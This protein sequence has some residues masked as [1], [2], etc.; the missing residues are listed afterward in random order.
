V[1]GADLRTVDGDLLTVFG[2]FTLA[3]LYLGEA[4][5]AEAEL[6]TL[7]D[8]DKPGARAA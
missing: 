4:E 8:T 6:P 7:T 2:F 5:V 3:A 1:R